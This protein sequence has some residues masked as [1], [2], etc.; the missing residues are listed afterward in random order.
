[1]KITLIK[2]N[3]GCKEHSLYVDEGRME[4]LML[5]LLAALTPPDVE[6]V[7][8]DDRMET[9]N[10]NEPTDLVAITVE[11]YTARRAYE[12]AGEYKD[13]GVPVILGGIH[14]TLIPEEA[15]KHSDSIF[16]GDAETIWAEVVE[17]ARKGNL[18]KVYKA[19]PGIGQEG[20]VKPRRGLFNG[21]GYL[22]ISLIQY[23]R[24][25]SYS[26]N[27]CAVSA[28]FNKGHYIRRIDEVIEEVVS[29]DRKLLF[30]VDDNIGFNHK[31]LKDLC[32]ELIPLKVNWVSQASIDI[33][34]D[35]ELLQ[36]MADSGCIGNVIGFESITPE[37]LKD[38]CKSTNL[39]DFSNY[40]AFKRGVSSKTEV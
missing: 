18:K 21:K 11:T 35:R 31:A 14:V 24:G 4:P 33:T 3:I 15:E 20:G 25:C 7:L 29:Q 16:I 26:C 2:P 8:Y 32:K 1:M 23:S 40:L 27:F 5:G 12:I 34:R 19:P 37:S 10:Y 38:A 17:D 28:Y 36:V 22:P 9:V 30:F 13:R 39:K 6:V